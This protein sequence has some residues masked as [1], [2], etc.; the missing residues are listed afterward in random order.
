MACSWRLLVVRPSTQECATLRQCALATGK[1]RGGERADA[2]AVL[3][4]IKEAR[5]LNCVMK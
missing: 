3:E 5:L 4:R 1:G 2:E